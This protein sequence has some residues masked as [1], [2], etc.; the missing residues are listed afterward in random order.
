MK[1]NVCN[2]ICEF[3]GDLHIHVRLFAELNIAL[4]KVAIGLR[5]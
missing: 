2:S 3:S 1:Y 5:I 4:P